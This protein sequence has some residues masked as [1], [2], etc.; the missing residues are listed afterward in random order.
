MIAIVDGYCI[1][2]ILP[3]PGVSLQGSLFDHS[4]FGSEDEVVIIHIILVFK[5]LGIDYRLDFLL[6]ID[7]DNV[8]DRSSLSSFGAFRY[9]IDLLPKYSTRFREDQQVIMSSGYK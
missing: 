2:P 5:V 3:W 7:I 4:F 9:G 1:D 8:L 6:A